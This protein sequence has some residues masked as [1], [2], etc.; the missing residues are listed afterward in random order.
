MKDHPEDRQALKFVKLLL[1][2]REHYEVIVAKAFDK[3]AKF[4]KAL[5]DGFEHV[6]NLK[7]N[8]SQFITLF[9]DD[10]MKDR[11]KRKANISTDRTLDETLDKVLTVFKH[12]HDRDVFEDHYKQLLAKRLLTKKKNFKADIS[13]AAE[14]LMISKL[15]AEIGPPFTS[16][17][18]NMLRDINMSADETKEFK[19][20]LKKTDSDLIGTFEATVLT[21]GSW[22][23][24]VS[25]DSAVPSFLQ[26]LLIEPYEKFYLDK[27]D[28]RKLSWLHNLG[29][30]EIRASFGPPG[31]RKIY[32]LVVSTY[33]MFVLQLFN[34]I[35]K[36]TFAD[37]LEQTKV[38]AEDLRRHLI[39]LAAPKYRVL[40]KEPRGK[41]ILGTDIFTVN[42][43]FSSSLN[44]LRIPLVSA[45]TQ[46]TKVEK[47][48]EMD[49]PP[50]VKEDRKHLTEAAIV[51]IMKAR[52]SMHNNMLIAEAVKQLAPR[53]KPTPQDVK[54]RIEALL[55]RDY[56]ERDENDRRLYHYIA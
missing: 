54:L 13:A 1:S 43:E 7:Q 25:P 44:R 35:G 9:V 51:R 20:S 18:E 34:K 10:L 14:H 47:P 33:Q 53:F 29:S 28:G 16:K 27:H 17:L 50:Q 56:I 32:T 55:E 19:A 41:I 26:N 5:K 6:V 38:P 4:S 21:T 24:R 22:P 39:S 15:K 37:L 49:I 46:L 31:N 12:L 42:E 3:N 48:K 52:K 2:H 36:F 8:I 30:A 11:A 40:N 45:R 23:Y